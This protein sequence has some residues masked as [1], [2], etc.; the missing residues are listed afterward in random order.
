MRTDNNHKHRRQM[1]L[2]DIE[3]MCI[4][5]VVLYGLFSPAPSFNHRLDIEAQMMMSLG[6]FTI[7]PPSV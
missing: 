7:V 5:V 1:C 3:L 2:C 6:L 4:I